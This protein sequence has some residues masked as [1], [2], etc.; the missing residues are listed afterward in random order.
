MSDIKDLETKSLGAMIDRLARLDAKYEKAAHVAKL[1]KERRDAY[2]AEL[3]NMF[4]EA[5]LKGATGSLARATVSSKQF[6][7]I[8]DSALFHEWCIA[9]KALDMFQRRI[10]LTA[11]KERMDRGIEEIPGLRVF[12]KKTIRLGKV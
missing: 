9:N 8:A 5:E 6:V 12:P 11:F 3:L 1:R 4:T 10:N 7:S 2:E